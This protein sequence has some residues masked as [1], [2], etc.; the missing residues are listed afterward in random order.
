VAVPG[1]DP[2]EPEDEKKKAARLQL[3]GDHESG[4]GDPSPAAP[5]FVPRRP[6]R[7][8]EKCLDLQAMDSLL[9]RAREQFERGAKP[10]VIEMLVRAMPDITAAMAD[11]DPSEVASLVLD[12]SRLISFVDLYLENLRAEGYRQAKAEKSRSLDISE[13]R[14]EGSP[15]LA[16]A[17]VHLAAEED[18]DDER[19]QSSEYEEI[20]DRIEKVQKAQRNQVVRRTSNRLRA[21]IER[22]AIEVLRTNGAPD[23]VVSRVVR[24]QIES[25]SFKQDAGLVVTKAFSMGR[26]QFIREHADEVETMKLSAVLDGKQCLACDRL[27]G[28]EIE[29]GSDE[30][31]E[32]TPPLAGV[33]DGADNCRCLLVAV[34]KRSGF[35]EV[36]E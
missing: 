12:D 17:P 29:L 13:G 5:T 35:Q 2:S 10:V 3:A 28:T 24:R 9:T 8:E 16:S 4:P 30:H 32:L 22:E 26:D 11:G 33:C 21:D 7:P 15:E 19:P 25:A 31:D 18:K 36:E 34:W 27:D 20:H 14:A 1:L 23:E 6:L